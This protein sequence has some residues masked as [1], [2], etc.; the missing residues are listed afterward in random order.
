MRKIF[1]ITNIVLFS[2]AIQAQ[3]LTSTPYDLMLETAHEQFEKGDF[4]N[5]VEWYEKCYKEQREPDIAIL[6]G[7][8]HYILRDYKRSEG[9]YRRVL[10]RDNTN[11]YLEDRYLYAKSLKALGLYPEAAEQF[12]LFI[13]DTGDMELKALAE[14]EIQ[15]MK[16]AKSLNENIEAEVI[17]GGNNI[18]TP[19]TEFSPRYSKDGKVYFAAIQSK[20]EIVMD[21]KTDDYYSQIYVAEK[22]KDGEFGK[23]QALNSLINRE[24][25]HTGNVCFTADGQMMFFT[26]ALLEKNE[27][28]DSRLFYSQMTDAGWGP[29]QEV[30]GINGNF[31]IRH[32]AFGEL[33]GRE[34]I[35]FSSN[36]PG[37]QGGFDIYY[38][39]RDGE[40]KF[41]SPVN[42]GP[43]INTTKDEIT[44]FY[45]KGTLYFSSDGLPVL[46]GFDIFKTTWDGS[47]WSTVENMGLN[48][49][50]PTDD[51][52]FSLNESGSDG[53]LI[54]NRPDEK[55]RTLQSKTCC[56]DI[57]TIHIR[58]I[59][60]DLQAQIFDEAGE[61]VVGG[62]MTLTDLSG[63]KDPNSKPNSE[64]NEYRFL[65]DSDRSYKVVATHPSYFP[66]TL[67]FNTAGIIDDYTVKKRMVLKALPKEPDFEI[68]TINQDIRLNNIYY[69][70]DDWKILPDAEKDLQTLVDLM[71]RYS[72]MVIELSSHTD[73]QGIST[74]NQSLSQKRAESAKA[75]IVS[76][77]IDPSRI[78]PV[79]YGESQILNHCVN[80]VRCTD[81]EHRFNRRTTF[82]IIAGPQTIEMKKEVLRGAEKKN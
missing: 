71:M 29:P 18:N 72:D 24:D 46:G 4:F 44:P 69:D 20:K 15:G 76:K 35:F 33:F 45:H 23:P 41:S 34:V 63:A 68:V 30:S 47:S 19:F 1:L 14:V 55:K 52:F 65:L 16:M 11:E 48:Y 21:G 22:D 67:E 56:D 59:V 79:G 53:F 32:P 9:Y 58:D 8:C 10:A 38:A 82:K 37:G 27:L 60:I 50:T 42:L 31:I 77:G 75:W 62:I 51:M 78:N 28:S 74:Y 40:T 39:N 64:S 25:F 13:K 66:D 2:V 26:R 17:F 73:A 49:N 54:S 61:P 7:L 80:G 81:D 12:G 57:Y 70:F 36:M 43:V 6:L 5:A 3:P